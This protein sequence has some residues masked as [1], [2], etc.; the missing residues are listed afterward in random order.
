[1]A[2]THPD[3]FH[4][5]FALCDLPLGRHFGSKSTYRT[6]HPGCLYVS[7]CDAYLSDGRKIW[8]G[9]IDLSTDDR[10]RLQM[11]AKLLR[12]QVYVLSEQVTRDRYKLKPGIVRAEALFVA[13]PRGV[14]VTA[15]Y[16]RFYG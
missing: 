7:N 2:I 16:R 14:K 11:V 3:E 10:R 1:M 5:A 12:R 15:M 8:G 4:A 6:K 13:S 9:D